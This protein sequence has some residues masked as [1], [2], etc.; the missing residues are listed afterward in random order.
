MHISHGWS[1]SVRLL[2]SSLAMDLP[3]IHKRLRGLALKRA[4]FALCVHGTAGIGK[5]HAVSKLLQDAPCAFSSL[6]ASTSFSALLQSL[7]KPRA[8][9]AWVQ[10]ITAKLERNEFIENAA[11][12]D[13]I[14]A[15]LTANAPLILHLEDIH[16]VSPDHLE[17]LG[18]LADAVKRTRGVTLI[19]TS[20]SPP[21]ESFE[22]VQLEPLTAEE[23][24]VLLEGEVAAPLPIEALSWIYSRAAGNP[25]FG[26]EFFRHLA[27]QGFVWNDA[28]RWHWRAP[29]SDTLPVTVE[30]LIEQLLIG[31][32]DTPDLEAV[33]AVKALLPV[34]SSD[35]LCATV[36]D[37]EIREFKLAQ[38][39]LEQRGVLKMGE[40]AHPLYREVTRQ[41]LSSPQRQRLARRA[42]VALE[43][44]PEQAI[45]FIESA[46][47]LPHEA[48]ELFDASIGNLRTQQREVAAAQLMRRSLSVRDELHRPH[49]ALEALRV[50]HEVDFTASS[51]LLELAMACRPLNPSDVLLLSG[52]LAQRGRE[53]GALRLLEALDE[54]E[55]NEQ[56]LLEWRTGLAALAGNTKLTLE[57]VDAH[58][59]LLDSRQPELIQRLVNVL[60]MSGRG[61]EAL[62]VGL[63]GLSMSL[64]AAQRATLL[65][66][67]ATAYF[68]LGKNA[69]AIELWS[70]A[71]DLASAHQLHMTAMKA[72]ISRAQALIRMGEKAQ[73]ESDL[74]RG[75]KLAREFGDRR[76]Y[77][78]SLVLFGVVL[79]ERGDFVRAEEKLLEGL[80]A[81][82]A[83][84]LLNLLL[85]LEMALTELYRVWPVPH[86]PILMHKYAR[87]VFQHAQEL[88]NTIFTLNAYL[89][90]SA[91]E[92]RIGNAPRALKLADEAL[93]LGRQHD[94]GFQTLSALRCRAAALEGLNDTAA[95]LESWREAVNAAQALDLP[96]F[97]HE[98]RLQACRL[99]ADLDGAAECLAWLE[100]NGHML[101]AQS[102]RQ[103]FPSLDTD[104]A[105]IVAP[106]LLMLNVLGPIQIINGPPLR[107]RKRQELLAALLEARIAGK[108]EIT[109]LELLDALYSDEDEDRAASSLKELVRSIRASCGAQTIQTTAN[110]YALGAVKS[111]AEAFLETG[112]TSLW[113]GAYLGGLGSSDDAVCESLH[114][115][116]SLQAEQH[117]ETDPK[118]AARL[119][120]LLLEFDPYSQFHLRLTLSALKAS[121]QRKTVQRLYDEARDRMGEVGEVLP[122]RWQDFLLETATV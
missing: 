114:L 30:A 32:A 10:A 118:E 119:G 68:H 81:C 112:N 43:A 121:D 34:H 105:A 77:L 1:V 26:L 89:A 9:P 61:E 84:G 33:L 109:R 19:V 6:H 66:T 48:C 35:A 87:Q 71:I 5:T 17:W 98:C 18:K 111:D 86:A 99:N 54:S 76:V 64:N 42:I 12:L 29:P 96:L 8:L 13:A 62:R 103:Y 100:A 23:T 3:M 25:L 45:E 40:F 72:T 59:E 108:A 50:L 94:R 101:E 92:L 80:S 79:T 56:R 113:R 106:P 55:R 31:A 88:G 83:D 69:E 36:S 93:V 95:A 60:A 57:L 91:A 37:L 49:I 4:G 97:I 22:A 73:A 67:T 90:L 28:R 116:L 102:A 120:K 27:R 122:E 21:P 53:T 7:P 15:T 58:P 65:L 117:L 20:R 82:P 85:N 2:D 16:E 11:L 70:R 44:T 115:A 78:Q 107:G 63:R 110:G 39:E 104:R 46:H 47:L 14:Q 74:E 52:Q 41:R 75:S 38:A 51:E 24:R